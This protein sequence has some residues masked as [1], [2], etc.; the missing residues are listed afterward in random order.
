VHAKLPFRS[1]LFPRQRRQKN[2]LMRHGVDV[3]SPS[4]WEPQEEGMMSTTASFSLSKKPRFNRIQEKSKLQKVM[5]SS[6]LTLQQG[7][8]L[9]HLL[10][11][12]QLVAMRNLHTTQPNT[13]LPTYD[14][15]VNLTG[16]LETKGTSVSSGKQ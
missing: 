14:E 9:R 6:L 2:V 10:T 11:C 5:L 7:H 16:L 13:L 15:V 1:L 4:S 12:L 3:I 8:R